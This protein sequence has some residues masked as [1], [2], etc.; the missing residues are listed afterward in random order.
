MTNVNQI[1]GGTLKSGAI[2]NFGQLVVEL[3]SDAVGLADQE[4][5]D[6]DNALDTLTEKIEAGEAPSQAWSEVWGPYEAKARSD[7]WKA[8]MGAL[9]QCVSAFDTFVNALGSML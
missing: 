4:A 2:S 6:F 9:K 3:S 1:I 5:Q 7:A 8:A